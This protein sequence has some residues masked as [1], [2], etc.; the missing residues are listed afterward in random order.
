MK[1][2]DSAIV[3]EP[4]PVTVT[5]RVPALSRALFLAVRALV[6]VWRESV[7]AHGCL[8]AVRVRA[9]ASGSLRWEVRPGGWRLAGRYL[10]AELAGSA[11]SPSGETS[12][13]GSPGA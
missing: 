7:C 10:P 6:Q 5:A 8:R 12:R 2:D 1:D 4:V 9:G 13:P 3:C 11:G